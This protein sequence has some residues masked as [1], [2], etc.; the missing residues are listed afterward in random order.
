MDGR[1]KAITTA[2]RIGLGCMGISQGY[3]PA[4]P[5][6]RAIS[7]IRQALDSGVRHLDTA[8]IYGSG[9]NEALIGESLRGRRDGVYLSS[10]CGLFSESG[11][12]TVNGHPAALRAGCDQALRRL[13]TDYID[14]YYLHRIDRNVPVED[15]VGA[16]SDLLRDG[17]IGAI[18][19]SEVSSTTLRRAH[20]VHPIAAVQ[21]EYSLWTRNPE[22][23]ILDACEEL[24]T[25]FVAFSPLGRGFF[26]GEVRR[27]PSFHEGDMRRQMPRFSNENLP[28]NLLLAAAL[29]ELAR[30]AE[31]T[32]AQLA[33]R[34]LLSRRRH[35][36]AIPGTTSPQHLQ[37]NV[38]TESLEIEKQL[39]EK[40]GQLIREY[41]VHGSRY[42][43]SVKLDSDIEPLMVP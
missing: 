4:M 35:I 24:G 34:W 40:A 15:S 25:A 10:K 32:P 7:L 38:V 30:D 29:K 42:D 3:G 8:A 39:I 41:P 13:K 31:C 6:R 5:Q 23:G 28:K 18:G 20:S 27:V 26:G 19:L 9:G 1:L 2:G 16:L 11:R 33:L 43:S 14:L 22:L 37:E 21:S 12:R 17:K 36:I